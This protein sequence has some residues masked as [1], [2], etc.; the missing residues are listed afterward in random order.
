MLPDIG[1]M[2][3]AYIFVRMV[4]LTSRPETARVTRILAALTAAFTVFICLDLLLRGTT[5]LTWSDVS[6]GLRR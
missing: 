6:E 3:G 4:H 2:I 1:L 5:N